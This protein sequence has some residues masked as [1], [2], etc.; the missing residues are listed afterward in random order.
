[1]SKLN[2]W[3]WAQYTLVGLLLA[4]LIICTLLPGRAQRLIPKITAE[5]VLP[6]TLAIVAFGG[7][8]FGMIAWAM[9][10]ALHRV[11]EWPIFFV[12]RPLSKS[13]RN[14]RNYRDMEVKSQAAKLHKWK[15]DINKNIP[16]Y[17]HFL[18]ELYRSSET[19]PQYLGG[20]V[21]STW[22]S[23]TL[24]LSVAGCLMLGMVLSFGK[25][26]VMLFLYK[27]DA[28]VFQLY[29]F[30]TLVFLYFLTGLA[31][32]SRNRLL[33]RDVLM[34]Y[35]LCKERNAEPEYPDDKH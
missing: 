28:V 23:C 30:P 24:M 4:T 21:V 17:N 26:L 19:H 22:Q 20:K 16:D 10:V 29:L 12:F 13:T 25:L 34:S 11:V 33:V 31:L 7:Y 5:K 6:V 1:M 3:R 14:H 18:L 9:I 15:A 32:L 35:V 2:V 27:H 8:I